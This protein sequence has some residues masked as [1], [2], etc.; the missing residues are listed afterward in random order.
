MKITATRYGQLKNGLKELASIYEKAFKDY[1]EILDI[2]DSINGFLLE[3]GYKLQIE[4]VD[5]SKFKD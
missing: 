1:D 2:I 5:F 3:N 4:P